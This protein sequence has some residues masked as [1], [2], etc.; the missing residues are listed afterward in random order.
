MFIGPVFSREAVITP[1]R[2]RLYVIRTVYAISLFILMCTAWLV[3]AG[4]QIVSDLGDM[5][6][7]GSILFKILAPLQLA[8]ILFMAAIQAVSSVAQEKDKKTIILLLMTRMTNSELVLGR[9]SA[10]L[11]NIGVLLATGLPIF[12]FISLFGGVSIAQISWSFAVTLLSALVAGSLGSTFALWREKTFQSLALTGVTIMLWIGLWE[13]LGAFGP[14]AFGIE[15]G[16]WATIFSPVSATIRSTSS[17]VATP[18]ETGVFGYL[19]FCVIATGL[20][21]GVAIWRV[22]YWNPSRDV[23]PGQQEERGA[24]SIWG[25]EHD[26]AQGADESA[27]SKVAEEA[28]QGHVDARVRKTSQESRRVWDNPVLWREICT[29]AYG[30]KIIFIKVAYWLLFISCLA[31]L[32]LA[33]QSG[34]VGVVRD[35]I[36]TEIS[37]S[38]RILGPFLLL[39]LVL[40]NAL[41]VTS[42]TN[43]RDGRSLDI[44]LVT[45]LSPKEFLFGKLAGI[46][47][48]TKEMVILPLLLPVF[49]WYFGGMSLE[50]LSYLLISL[51]I[52]NIFVGTLGIHCGMIYGNSRQAIG[53]S[54]G[55]V[56]FLFLGVMTCLFMMVSFTGRFQAQ[57]MPFLAFIVGGGIGLYVTLGSRN[58][59]AA[60]ALASGVLPL[61]MFFSITSFLLDRPMSVF[62]VLVFTFG[63]TTTAMIMPALGEY[64]I[65]MGRSKT[66]E[67]E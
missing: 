28:R 6:R 42:I 4:T 1:R 40:V 44:L 48:V 2:P 32:Y 38:A 39:S 41:A 18:F 9:L 47:Y 7:F 60:I 58:P 46:L 43:E 10:S 56:F 45:D 3:L 34:A 29:W 57:L 36:G 13:A 49:L 22:R 50:E 31:G 25:V 59:S 20:L 11:L 17:S 65:A 63:F 64:N 12:M 55:T 66:A 67:D 26:L 15:A 24:S 5:A 35:Q 33:V 14:S 53:V 23:R 19:T 21:N 54:L 61:A 27:T 62:L 16:T 52:L 51:L 37:V 8:L 30:R